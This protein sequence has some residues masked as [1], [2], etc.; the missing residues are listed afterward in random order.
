MTT[1]EQFANQRR[2]A[3]ERVMLTMYFSPQGQGHALKRDLG[4]FGEQKERKAIKGRWEKAWGGLA[5][6]GSLWWLGGPG[7]RLLA[8]KRAEK[9][10]EEVLSG[11]MEEATKMG[12]NGK[13]AWLTNWKEVMGHGVAGWF[14]ESTRSLFSRLLAKAHHYQSQYRSARRPV[15]RCTT[16]STRD[17][18]W[19]GA[20]GRGTH[21]LR[22]C[23]DCEEKKRMTAPSGVRSQAG[24]RSLY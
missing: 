18:D 3:R 11:E 17:L 5:T 20:G 8:Q 23:D 19:T 10:K 6:R 7:E 15:M 9:G 16:R 14:C 21:G 12:V 13:G 22:I 1:I 24:Q 4:P 2:E